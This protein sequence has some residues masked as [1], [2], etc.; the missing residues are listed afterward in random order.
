ML[1]VNQQLTQTATMRHFEI[2]FMKF[3]VGGIYKLFKQVSENK[4]K[5][6]VDLVVVMTI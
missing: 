6:K 1:F 3:N 4:L 5:M 2:I